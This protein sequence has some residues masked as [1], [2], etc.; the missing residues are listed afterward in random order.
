MCYGLRRTFNLN[1]KSRPKQNLCCIISVRSHCRSCSIMVV[2][3]LL[4]KSTNITTLQQKIYLTLVIHGDNILWLVWRELWHNP[5]CLHWHRRP[6]HRRVI[7]NQQQVLFYH[8]PPP[9]TLCQFLSLEACVSACLSLLLS[10]ICDLLSF[11]VVFYGKATVLNLIADHMVKM[12][13]TAHHHPMRKCQEVAG[14]A[15]SVCR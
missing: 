5:M 8:F 15:L 9:L 11:V 10:C 4:G 2:I 3:L 14:M 13:S 12:I 7:I 1:Q 6:H